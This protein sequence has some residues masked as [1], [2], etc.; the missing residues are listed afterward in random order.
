MWWRPTRYTS[1][2]AACLKRPRSRG[3]MPDYAV[4]VGNY[5]VQNCQAETPTFELFSPWGEQLPQFEMP[6]FHGENMGD[7]VGKLPRAKSSV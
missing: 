3:I 2:L 5:P 6:T 7:F 4:G 1:G